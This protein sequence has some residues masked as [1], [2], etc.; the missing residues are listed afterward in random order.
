MKIKITTLTAVFVLLGAA[1]ISVTGAQAQ[2]SFSMQLVADNDFAVFGGTATSVN[3]LIYQNDIDWQYQISEMSALNFTLQPGDTM[4]YVL[5][6]GGGGQ[7]NISGTVNG[8]DITSINVSMSSDLGSYLT[9]YEYQLA[10]QYGGTPAGGTYNVSLAD[11]QTAF[12]NLTWGSPTINS[13][14]TVIHQAS[15]NGVGYDFPSD[16]ASLF[17][18]N[19]TEAGVQATPEP[20]TTAL[21]ALGAF[22]VLFYRRRA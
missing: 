20:N 1:G 16:T 6:I 7:E 9:G 4:F 18:F 21:A 5:G 22:A 14:D 11:V 8:V 13:S 10:Q 15:P 2:S 12:P 19:A 3:D 17:S